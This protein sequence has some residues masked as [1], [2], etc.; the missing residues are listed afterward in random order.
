MRKYDFNHKELPSFLENWRNMV[1]DEYKDEIYDINVKIDSIIMDTP[2]N[3]KE[4]KRLKYEKEIIEGKIK[5]MKK[6]FYK[7]FGG[8][9]KMFDYTEYQQPNGVWTT[10]ELHCG[11]KLYVNIAQCDECK[12]EYGEN[13]VKKYDMEGVI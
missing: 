9:N 11:N 3:R 13:K 2:I 6:S 5:E 12:E 10:G 4:L 1:V 8:C 7:Y